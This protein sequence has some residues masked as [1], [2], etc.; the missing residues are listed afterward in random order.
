VLLPA[1]VFFGVLLALGRLWRDSEM[2]VLAASGFDLADLARPLLLLALPAA[3]VLA[4]I[5]FWIAP[6]AVGLSRSL[7]DEANRSLI[8]A[9]LEPGRFVDLPGRDGVI[10]VGEMGHGGTTFKRM[11]VES[12]RAGA[13]GV[14]RLDITTAT[15]GFLYHDADGSGR[16]LALL[17]GFRVEGHPG[18]DDY[19]LM[20]FVRNDLKLP[21]SE[22]DGSEGGGERAASTAALLANATP[23]ARAELDWR[24]AAPLSGLILILLALPLSKSSPREPRY[25]R[26]LLAALFYLAYANCLALGRSWIGQGKLAPGFGLWWVY[27]PTVGFAVWLIWRNGRFAAPRATRGAS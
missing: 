19:R 18:V 22:T 25:A 7:L 12:E 23:G 20:R 4:A 5:S 15:H 1:A 21:D 27:L 9:G 16:Y 11:F 24:L 8:V 6:A 17:D 26:L 14:P 3:A 10:Y 13:D 2:A